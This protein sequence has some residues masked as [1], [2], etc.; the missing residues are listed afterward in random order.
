[1][2]LI[3]DVGS[4]GFCTVEGKWSLCELPTDGAMLARRGKEER[5]Y[6]RHCMLAIA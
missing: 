4:R 5:G 2:A 1:M 6:F 3:G